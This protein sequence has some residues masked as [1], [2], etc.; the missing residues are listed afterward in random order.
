MR[1]I[2]ESYRY[3]KILERLFKLINLCDTPGAH[4]YRKLLEMMFTLMKL[5]D[6][7]CAYNP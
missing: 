1:N 4:T 2:V 7:S 5:F 6:K 3:R